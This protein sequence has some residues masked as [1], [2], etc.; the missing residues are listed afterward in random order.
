M[1]GSR[2]KGLLSAAFFCLRGDLLWTKP[3]LERPFVLET[4]GVTPKACTARQ[5]ETMMV[6]KSFMVYDLIGE[7]DYVGGRCQRAGDVRRS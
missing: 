7:L 6:E 2:N 3:G 1:R 4:T 5:D